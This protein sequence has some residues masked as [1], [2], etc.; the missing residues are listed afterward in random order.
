MEARN[1][2][3]TYGQ[4]TSEESAKGKKA[5]F[6]TIG[7]WT[8]GCLNVIKKQEVGGHTPRDA[9]PVQCQLWLKQK[10]I[11]C[12]H[13]HA[14][15]GTKAGY[16]PKGSNGGWVRGWCDCLSRLRGSSLAGSLPHPQAIPALAGRDEFSHAWMH[17]WVHDTD[18]VWG[19]EGA[20]GSELSPF[21]LWTPGP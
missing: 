10:E 21:M 3:R 2:P 13:D 9:E 18:Q 6:S 1:R 17:I 4:L 20:N 16:K 15:R 11:G 12:D 5:S 7:A 14:G 19:K 8:T